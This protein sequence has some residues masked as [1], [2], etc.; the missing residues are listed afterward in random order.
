LLYGTSILNPDTDGD[1]LSDGD[2]VYLHETDPTNPDSDGDGFS[3]GWE[4]ENNT[5]PNRGPAT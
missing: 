4:I 5:D 2:E 1:G 3:D